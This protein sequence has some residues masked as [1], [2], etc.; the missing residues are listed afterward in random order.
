MSTTQLYID[1]KKCDYVAVGPCCSPGT[2]DCTAIMQPVTT[3]R[4]FFIPNAMTPNCSFIPTC[5][6]PMD[7]WG[8]CPAPSYNRP[9]SLN[10]GILERSV[11]TN[12]LPDPRLYVSSLNNLT[13]IYAQWLRDFNHIKDPNMT[14]LNYTKKCAN[15]NGSGCC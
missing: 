13:R 5:P 12:A 15:F 2:N 11:V 9:T 1:P 6:K 3:E 4:A 7:A 8:Q 10:P 14:S